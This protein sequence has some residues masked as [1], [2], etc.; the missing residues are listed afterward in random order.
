MPLSWPL[1]LVDSAVAAHFVAAVL[2]ASSPTLLPA[3][4]LRGM[5]RSPTTPDT[6]SLAGGMR[7]YLYRSLRHD[8]VQGELDLYAA[9]TTKG[10]ATMVCMGR[11]VRALAECGSIALSVQLVTGRPLPLGRDAAFRQGLVSTLS[12]SDAERR[13][14]RAMLTGARTAAEQARAV[15]RLARGYR[16][17]AG[18]LAP[19][20][21]H[22]A[23]QPRAI[24]QALAALADIYGRV[25]A[26]LRQ[27]D[28]VGVERAERAVSR[29][30]VGL[31]RLLDAY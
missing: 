30:L 9:P 17:A 23:G 13:R 5:G 21:P 6:V 18:V 15:E 12:A 29:R 28:R 4:F 14:V 1:H 24:V 22:A 25:V 16:H 19:L 7:A 2:P 26:S 10:I 8:G 20:A 31:R 11:R 27:G 3:E